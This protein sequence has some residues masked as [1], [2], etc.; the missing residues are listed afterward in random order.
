MAAPI[1]Q[2]EIELYGNV[3]SEIKYRTE[4]ATM[5]L[6]QVTE[7]IE[8]ESAVLQLRKSIE[9]V[10]LGT[11]AANAQAVW[12]VSTT[13][14]TK[15]W[16]D[17]RRLLRRINPGYWPVPFKDGVDANGK[18]SLQALRD[19]FLSE[20]QVG[21][22]WGFLSDLLHA[23][24]PF[25]PAEIDQKCLDR[26]REISM[27]LRNLLGL[28]TADLGNRKHLLLAEMDAPPEGSVF[29]RVLDE[30]ATVTRG[31]DN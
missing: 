26:V 29:V 21:G 9:L 17:A 3:L 12:Q 23:N 30:V 28:H 22:A 18:R 4:H 7:I 15:N 11:L 8:F 13:L 5:K 16:K 24:N 14:H 25:A 20:D 19:P 27:K 6:V 1:T 10:A 31:L 2:T